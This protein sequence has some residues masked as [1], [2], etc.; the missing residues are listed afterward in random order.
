MNVLNKTTTY[1]AGYMEFGKD[2]ANWRQEA[3]EWLSKDFG[4]RVFNPYEKPFVEQIEENEEK[5]AYLR[6][7]MRQGRFDEAQHHMKRIRALD[8]AMVDK[9]DFLIAY[10][11]PAIPT[12]GTVDE[13][14]H[15][16][17]LR[18]PVFTVVKGGV[19][20][21][22]LW[23]LATLPMSQFF[24]NFNELRVHLN[25]INDGVINTDDKYWRLVRPEW[26]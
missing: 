9:A 1:L 18:K 26:R 11:D 10:I 13:I 12:Y 16:A 22:P 4:V 14:C 6:N 2:G 20:E 25:Q 23:I 3:T 17:R 8:L 5:T 7:E 15:A 19:A 21:V 24:H